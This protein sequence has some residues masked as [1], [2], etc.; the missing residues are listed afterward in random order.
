MKKILVAFGTRPEAIK[1]CELIRNLKEKKC[2]DVKVLVT[3]QHRGMLKQALK[4][5]GIMP[6]YDLKIMKIGQTLSYVTSEVLKK[7]DEAISKFMPDFVIVHGDTSS[8]FAVA[9]AAFY[10]GIKIVH[11]EAGLR[12]YDRSSPFPEEFNRAAIS[13]ISDY[14][15]APTELAKENLISEKISAASIFVTGNTVID[16]LIKNISDDYTSEYSNLIGEKKLII[17]TAH[18]RENIDKLE[19]IFCA[20]K[21]IVNEFDNIAFIY[22]VHKNKKISLL[23]KKVFLDCP[24]VYLT[25][26]LP[27][28]DFH[29]LLNLSYLVMTDSGGVQEE[30]AYLKKP[31]LVLR[32]TTERKELLTNK[33]AKLVGTDENSIFIAAREMLQNYDN[34]I[35]NIIKTDFL[36]CGNSS[37]IIAD[38]LEKEIIER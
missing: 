6:D 8:A 14:H 28:Y 20:V 21:R 33:C 5:E 23:A 9:L 17:L 1:L 22:P 16:A 13:L 7:A 32:N 24:R 30:A 27:A 26:A 2:F 11:V 35:K 18:R 4:D 38:I 31:T 3:G 15:F 37:R 29:N 25:D 19:G 36:G 12:T 34:F 10:R